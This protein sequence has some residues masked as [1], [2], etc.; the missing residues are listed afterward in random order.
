MFLDEPCVENCNGDWLACALEVLN[1]NNV[2]VQSFAKS[3]RELLKRG[4]G[5]Y[6]NLM[7]IGPA[8]CGKTFL[9]NPLS[10]IFNCFQN[11]ATTSFARVGAE[12]AEVIFLNDFR[13]SPQ[14]L[15]WHDLLLHLEGHIVHLPAPKSHY[16]K[17]I[18][19]D[20]DTPI[21]CTSKHQFV[22]IKGGQIDDKETEMMAV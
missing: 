4:R 1:K 21:F 3:V 20:K 15:A 7:I 10:V 22:F 12:K 6:R 9:L 19:F 8:N 11:P 17:D 2:A 14:V 18:V 5:K 16:S 13:W